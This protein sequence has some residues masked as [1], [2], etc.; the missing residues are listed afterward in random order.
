MCVLLLLLLVKP[1]LP[2]DSPAEEGPVNV[3]VSEERVVILLLLVGWLPAFGTAAAGG[4]AA[5]RP[6]AI[7]GMLLLMP[8]ALPMAAPAMFAAPGP[9]AAVTVVDR[10]SVVR[11]LRLGGVPR[12]PDRSASPTSLGRIPTKIEWCQSL[13]F[14]VLAFTDYGHS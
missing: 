12:K 10:V 1:K 2:E 6:P 8:V 11:E 9:E 3:A 7:V 13:L 4:A 5:L 14:S